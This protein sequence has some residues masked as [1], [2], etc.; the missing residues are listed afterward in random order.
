M[1]AVQSCIAIGR[2]ES[3]AEY[4]QRF[5]ELAPNNPDAWK[6][7]GRCLFHTEDMLGAE[8]A[9]ARASALNP[10][11]VEPLLGLGDVMFHVGRNVEG[12]ACYQRARLAEPNNATVLFKLGSGLMQTQQLED[13]EALLRKAVSLDPANAAAHVN[14]ATV[15]YQAGRGPE[16]EQA[17]RTAVAADGNMAVAHETLGAI[18]LE[19]GQFEEAA[20]VLRRAN[21]LNRDRVLTLTALATAE[22]SLGRTAEAEEILQ[23]ILVIEPKNLEARHSIAALRGDPVQTV[24]PGYSEQLFNW[25]APRFDRLLSGPLQYRGPEETLALL[26]EIAPDRDSFTAFLD[27]GCGT[28]LIGEVIGEV[29][30][31]DREVGIDVSSRMITVARAKGVYDE[32]IHGDANG[33]LAANRAAFDLIT[34]IDMFIYV[35]DLEAIVPLIADALKADGLF[36][37]TIEVLDGADAATGY[38]LMPTGRFAH[39][40]SY[41]EERA[42]AAGLTPVA[43]KTITLRHEK[44]APVSAI[45]GALRR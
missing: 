40:L 42:R 18:L 31:M 8:H 30:R 25:F 4:I 23:R 13:A 2:Y 33:Y 32:L 44:G 21:A 10:L 43:A 5:L 12:L 20:A 35:G 7:L 39:T 14:I 9:F 41:I 19:Q 28:G 34:A 24:P 17:A 45:V 36:V 27:L 3:A 11:D 1:E 29:Y 22:T 6:A 38:K 15:L 26:R 16:A 37:Y